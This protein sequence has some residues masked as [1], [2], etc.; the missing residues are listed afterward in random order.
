MGSLIAP[1]EEVA[2]EVDFLHCCLL[3]KSLELTHEPTVQT[4][5]ALVTSSVDHVKVSI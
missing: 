1:C 5:V 4:V 3:K 2:L